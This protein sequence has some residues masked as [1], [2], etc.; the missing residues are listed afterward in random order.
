MK[1]LLLSIG[2]TLAMVSRAQFTD[3]LSDGNFDLNPVW[4]GSDPHFEIDTSGQL[5]L[6]APALKARSYLSTKSKAISGASWTFDLSLDFNPSSSNQAKVYLCS[7]AP[8]LTSPLNGYYVLIGGTADEV[9]LFRQQGT[10]SSKLIDG[11]DKMLDRDKIDLHITVTV[12]DLGLWEL[13]VDKLGN[14]Q[15]VSMGSAYDQGIDRSDWF[16]VLCEYTSTRST[17]FWFDNFVVTGHSETNKPLL[18]NISVDGLDK[19]ILKFSEQL[20][21]SSATDPANYLLSGLE[22]ISAA[23]FQDSVVL[24]FNSQTNGSV[25]L[26]SVSSIR[27]LSG[28]VINDTTLCCSFLIDEVAEPGD[29][30]ISEVMADPSPVVGQPDAEYLEL[31]NNSEKVFDLSHYLLLNSGSSRSLPSMAF[32]PGTHL[33]LCD[34]NSAALF[35]DSLIVVPVESWMSLANNGDSLVLTNLSGLAINSF[36]YTL[37]NNDPSKRNGG[38]SL[39]RIADSSLCD[40]F[41]LIASCTDPSGGTP[42]RVNSTQTAIDTLP[43]AVLFNKGHHDSISVSFSENIVTNFGSVALLNGDPVDIL[44]QSEQVVS[45]KLNGQG[46]FI[47]KGFK[48]CWGN[49]I[50]P[51]T[52]IAFSY[53]SPKPGELIISEIM[54]DPSPTVGLPDAEYIEV[55]N[56]T[57]DTLDLSGCTINSRIISGV[58][59]LA[60]DQFAILTDTSRSQLFNKEITVIPVL[61]GSSFL[62]N[63]GKKLEFRS[64]DSLLISTVDYR[65]EWHDQPSA[66]AGGVSI[67]LI[68]LQTRCENYSAIWKS[69]RSQSGGSPG[70]A[71]NGH[72]PFSTRELTPGFSFITG[73]TLSKRFNQPILQTGNWTVQPEVSNFNVFPSEKGISFVMELDDGLTYTLSGDSIASCYSGYSS[74]SFQI[75]N[76][77]VINPSSGLILNELLYDPVPE[78]VDFVELRNTS[79]D[80][81]S[82]NNCS[83]SNTSNEY[84]EVI[85]TNGLVLEPDGYILLTA[86]TSLIS[87]HH[88]SHNT[89]RMLACKLP[90]FPNTS[91]ELLLW[92]ADSILIDRFEYSDKLHSTKLSKTEGVSLERL[93]QNWASASASTGFA[94]PGLENAGST[95]KS[96][97]PGFSLSTKRLTANGDGNN[98]ELLISVVFQDPGL[99]IACSIYD[100]NGFC[101]R[102]LLKQTPLN[103]FTELSWNGRGDNNKT[104]ENGAYIAVLEVWD[105]SGKQQVEKEVVVLSN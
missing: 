19:I 75:A 60:P 36:T 68:D 8:D 87:S 70:N 30:L 62:T 6:K 61:L 9:S 94:S 44:F 97:S 20:D 14:G 27:D 34:D 102:S 48:D 55:Y 63:G 2:L 40:S 77:K 4:H 84:G 54:A 91:G 92:S 100:L 105:I 24:V 5:H 38:W 65:L 95:K 104:L 89:A 56:R 83:V 12:S 96:T 50:F 64:P 1:W 72:D 13:L 93:G 16:G 45:W 85:S 21:S 32:L 52:I 47:L 28:N 103:G 17:K 57:D 98:D 80:Y 29:I 43:P 15:A 42:G 73:D 88:A 49:L 82:L 18:T 46:V 31:F 39:E 59:L 67:E 22:S 66:M 76:P 23:Y 11:I 90:N 78:S 3:D 74:V 26:L 99:V 69:S 58:S 101:V 7:T 10:S 79:T 71:N 81:L 51:D 25:Q 37:D 41:S 53:K 86:D 33:I 35:P